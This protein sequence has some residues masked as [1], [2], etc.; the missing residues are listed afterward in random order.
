MKRVNPID[1]DGRVPTGQDPHDYYRPKLAE[2]QR[3]N[4]ELR[5]QFQSRAMI[6][7]QQERLVGAIRSSPMVRAAWE[8]F[9]DSLVWACDKKDGIDHVATFELLLDIALDCECTRNQNR[10]TSVL[11]RLDMNPG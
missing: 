11:R 1:I 4:D 7:E 5:E 8:S 10:K 2:M 6:T 3:I 9:L